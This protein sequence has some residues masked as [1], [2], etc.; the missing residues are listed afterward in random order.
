VR[1]ANTIVFTGRKIDMRDWRTYQ[2]SLVRQRKRRLW[3]RRG[4]LLMV[5]A[6][7]AV[8]VTWS[9]MSFLTEEVSQIAVKERESHH[10][11]PA[12]QKVTQ[13][14]G[15]AEAS[16]PPTGQ[17]LTRDDLRA[18]FA[19]QQWG[20]QVSPLQQI[21]LSGKK[22][23]VATTVDPNLQQFLS[24]QL[25]RKTSLH[26]AIVVMEPSTGKI[27]A[28]VSHNRPNPGQNAC[29][30]I[31]FP[32]ASIFKIIAAA[33]AVE[34]TG[35]S[36]HSRM[37]FEGSKHTLY[38]AQLRESLGKGANYVTLEEAFADSVNPV[39]GRLGAYRLG[40][41]RLLAYAGAF[42]FN[43]K[44]DFELPTVISH[45]EISENPYQWAELASGFNRTTTLSA[46]HGALIAAAIYN[47]GTMLKPMLFDSISTHDGHVL[48]RGKQEV[49]HAAVGR[50]AASAVARMMLATIREG[51]GRKTF[52]GYQRDKV[53]SKLAIG[54]KT[55]SY[56]SNPRFDWFVGFGA[57]QK[58]K[59]AIAVSVVV[60]HKDYI[61]TKSGRYARMA[62]KRYFEE[63]D[64][65]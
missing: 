5:L 31:L 19:N 59:R 52:R 39:F 34:A 36:P 51:T 60:S 44:I 41:K 42:G 13:T 18:M 2:A 54:G 30:E 17:L 20:N 53:L 14:P 10:A 32:A 57:D 43:H 56:G 64:D 63:V 12:V 6:T 1:L 33:S 37:G 21:D 29:T 65:S 3:L 28:M 9:A 24:D 49:M 26:L 50:E 8:A 11:T 25:M 16:I 15:E 58:A 46:L 35:L 23:M 45:F 22:L 4:A 7:L 38:K 62:I 47:G 27:L 55:G 40:D 48:Y 61:G